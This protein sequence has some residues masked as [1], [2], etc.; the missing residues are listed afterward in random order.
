MS[1]CCSTTGEAHAHTPGPDKLLWGCGLIIITALAAYGLTGF[2]NID[3]P[4]LHHFGHSI[5][6]LMS[7]MWWGVLL[8]LFFVGLMG[9]VPKEYFTVLLG[10]GDSVGGIFRAAAAGVLLDL[11]SHGILMV[12]AKLYE[13]GASLGQIMTFLIASP[14]NS[15]S[16][17][18]ILVAMIG[19]KW[20]LV[21]I[22]G[23]MVIAIVTGLLYLLLVRAEILP[24]NPHTVEMPEDF[25]LIPDAKARLKN[26]RPTRKFWA[27]VFSEGWRDGKMVLRWLAF[28]IIL[29]A[30]IRTFIPLDNF[31]TWFAPTM[32]GLF[33]TLIATTLI[34]VCSEGSSPIGADLVTR[35]AAPGNG[36]AFLMA[37]VSTDYTEIMV[38]KNLTGSWKIALSLPILTVPQVFFL[39]W[40]LNQF[41]LA[42]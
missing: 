10:R 31:A 20:T 39:G 18:L 36:F 40:V 32:G 6:D 41:S 37:G 24:G 19:L 8:G 35:A 29:A 27:E 1:S 30:L 3:L 34:E 22:A 23:S 26:F 12:G 42:G 28:G 15:F 9:Q 14:W 13:R 21:F 38:L 33:L 5:L 17:T 25:R 4:Y 16:L 2:F 11:C 7:V